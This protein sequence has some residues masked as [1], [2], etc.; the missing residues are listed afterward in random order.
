MGR[1]R[2]ESWGGG[3]NEVWGMKKRQTDRRRDL[4][5]GREKRLERERRGGKSKI[6][7]GGVKI[8]RE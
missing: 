2:I 4:K 3:E 1:E 6:E 5:G 8:W 7:S